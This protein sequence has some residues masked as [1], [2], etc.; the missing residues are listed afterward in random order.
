MQTQCNVITF[1]SFMDFKFGKNISDGPCKGVL[2]GV[3]IG[4]SERKKMKVGSKIAFE[5]DAEPAEKRGLK[6]LDGHRNPKM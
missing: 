1:P 4:G 3:D 6:E 5:E 2:Y